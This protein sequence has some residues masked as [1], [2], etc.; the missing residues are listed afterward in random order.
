LAADGLQFHDIGGAGAFGALLDIKADV[1]TLD[2]RP[3]T[4]TI[5][6]YGRMVDKY[7]VAVFD[8][9]K[10]VTFGVIKPLYS[11]F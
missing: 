9:D 1:R 8:F 7:I 3:K 10:T 11:S 6:L 2:K 4:T 5:I